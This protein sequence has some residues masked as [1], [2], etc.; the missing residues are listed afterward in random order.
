MSL[1]NPH[2]LVA[3]A[4]TTLSTEE[5]LNASKQQMVLSQMLILI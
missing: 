5:P 4:S 2:I 1:E 3:A